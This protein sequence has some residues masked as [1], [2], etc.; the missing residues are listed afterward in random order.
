MTWSKSLS[1]PGPLG[2][3]RLEGGCTVLQMTPQGSIHGLSPGRQLSSQ[4]PTRNT[5][6]SEAAVWGWPWPWPGIAGAPGLQ[7]DHG[8]TCWDCSC[9]SPPLP[10]QAAFDHQPALAPRQERDLPACSFPSPSGP[11]PGWSNHM[12]FPHPSQVVQLP[13]RHILNLIIVIITFGRV[14]TC[15]F[16][17][18]FSGPPI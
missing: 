9:P 11:E 3:D 15:R 14:N 12:E 13:F 2:P 8:F 16:I 6:E 10:C 18:F 4:A 5:Q 17:W 1:V 7:E